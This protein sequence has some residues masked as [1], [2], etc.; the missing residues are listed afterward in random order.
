MIVISD[1]ARLIAENLARRFEGCELAAYQN[2]HDVPTI[3]YGHTRGVA[4]GMTCTEEQAEAWLLADMDVAAADVAQHAT[5]PL[6]DHEAAA[7]IDFAFNC[8]AAN[9]NAS[10]LLRELDAGNYA[11][12]PTQLNR[13]VHDA[14]G[15]VLNGLVNRRAA[16]GVC[17][18]MSDEAQDAA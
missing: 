9:L 11:D 4:L 3:G 17:W 18:N 8:G 12:V 15:N 5:V 2:P 10:T 6:T 14:S 13:W 1:R 7:L 16:E